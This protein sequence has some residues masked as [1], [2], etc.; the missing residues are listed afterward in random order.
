MLIAVL[1]AGLAV[2][3][4]RRRL[5]KGTDTRTTV[6]ALVP[7]HGDNISRL[8]A[9]VFLAAVATNLLPFK[10]GAPS[11]PLPAR[12]SEKVID[13]FRDLVPPRAR[14]WEAVRWGVALFGAAL[15]LGAQLGVTLFVDELVEMR[16]LLFPVSVWVGLPA[17]RS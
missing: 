9:N 15:W 3:A 12:D 17:S 11:R 13:E 1:G 10:G 4:V 6:A 7:P 14:R 2:A 5:R 8:E 16:A